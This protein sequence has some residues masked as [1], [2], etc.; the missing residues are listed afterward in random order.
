MNCALCSR[1]IPKGF[2]SKHHLVPKC[3]GG[4]DGV[5]VFMHSICH[6]QIH[7]LFNEKA[8][9]KKYNSIEK[10]KNQP[11]IQRFLAW[12]SVKPLEFDIKIHISRKNR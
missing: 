2:E 7:A 5:F 9:A 10:L 6:K 1:E 3:K 11:D 8:L 4:A 12:I